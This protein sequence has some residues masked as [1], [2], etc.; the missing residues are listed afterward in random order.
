MEMNIPNVEKEI[1][2]LLKRPLTMDSLKQF[3]LLSEAME[4]LGHVHREF[5]EEDAKAWYAHMDPPGK[6]SLEQTSAVMRTKGY[7]HDPCEFWVVMN[8]MYSD[9]GTVMARNNM[10]RPDVYADLAHH[11]IADSDA[12]EDKVGRYWRD[13][14]KR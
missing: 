7:H 8:A 1:Q 3:V 6:W 14:V 11:F 12:V 9:Y 2:N 5:T 4:Y 13:I 10:D